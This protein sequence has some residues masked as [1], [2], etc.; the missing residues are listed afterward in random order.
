[1]R[2]RFLLPFAPHRNGDH[3]GSRVMAEILFRMASRYSVGV[4]YL[5][6]PAEPDIEDELRRKCQVVACVRRRSSG[7]SGWEHF[8]WR[9]RQLTALIRG[10]PMWVTDWHSTE[11]SGQI[12][13]MAAEWQPD[14]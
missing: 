10:V 3:G 6:A 11:Y 14:I 13:Q 2:V 1:M 9:V 5:R 8:E 4:V 12:R 7:T